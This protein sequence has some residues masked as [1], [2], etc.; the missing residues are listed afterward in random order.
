[1]TL[2][3]LSLANACTCA[4]L[5]LTGCDEPF[6]K[7]EEGKEAVWECKHQPTCG[8]RQDAVL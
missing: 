3:K 2:A 7:P 8:G 1:M 5:L 4:C 6:Q